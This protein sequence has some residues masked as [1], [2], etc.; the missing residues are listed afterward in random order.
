MS[1]TTPRKYQNRGNPSFNSSHSPHSPHLH[2][3]AHS[4]S[5]EI[6]YQR[7]QGYNQGGHVRNR[8]HQLRA[9]AVE[10][11]YGI[12]TGPGAGSDYESDTARYM[13]KHPPPPQ[14]ALAAR[15]NTELNLGVLRR[16]R[17]SITSILAIAA[18]AVVYVY[19]SKWEKSNLEGTLFICAQGDNTEDAA[20]N[21][22]LFILNRKGLHNLVIN[23][24]SVSNFEPSK[25]LLMLMLDEEDGLPTV[26]MENGESVTPK[27]TGMYIHAES[28]PDRLTTS[29]LIHEMWNKARAAREA[30][31]RDS[32]D[33]PTS[34]SLSDVEEAVAPTMIE[35]G[36]QLSLSELFGNRH[37]GL[38][39]P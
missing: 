14:A 21:G 36:R 23:L 13:A 33:P 22:C 34:A 27:V 5:Q 29:A 19:T 20:S 11:Q 35:A 4:S 15:T 12:P 7:S 2:L 38:G 31:G 24:N 28:E 10:A 8:S 6:Q 26:P 25:D 17:P 32:A 9:Q 16:Y 18:N 37:N 3:H 1:Q 30:G 39:G